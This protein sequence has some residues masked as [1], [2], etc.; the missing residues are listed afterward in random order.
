MNNQ[1]IICPNDEKMNILDS[2]SKID[3]LHNIKF[4]NKK[5]FINNYYFSYDETAIQYLM[6]KY[7]Y[8]LD[9]CKVYL[10]YLY[11]IDI[12]K[13]Y[14]VKKLN[15]LKEIKKELLE[16]NLLVENNAFKEYI[17]DKNIKVL[18][19][20]DLDKYEEEA[21]NY[22][23]DIPKVDLNI[24]VVECETLEDEVNN[25]CLKVIEL[26]NNGIDINKIYLSNISNDYL[27]TIDRLF[28][29]TIDI[30]RYTSFTDFNT[31]RV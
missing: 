27:Y 3:N 16:N 24:D 29:N 11:V 6:D 13:E 8:N 7:N 12:N 30:G 15:F 22:K 18:N 17:K 1:V 26:L 21:L 20:Y 19:Y 2:Y 25:V 28:C 14:K 23:V 5:E 10:K 4:M 31:R 9:V